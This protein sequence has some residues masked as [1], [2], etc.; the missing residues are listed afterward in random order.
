ML[1]PRI[2]RMSLLLPAL[3][4]VVLAFSLSGQPGALRASLPPA[5][6]NGATVAGTIKS[7]Q[8]TDPVRTAGSTGD[9]DVAAK[10]KKQFGK[11]GSGFTV[12][13]DEFEAR[14]PAGERQLENV[15]ATRAGTS[16]NGGSIVVVAPR[17]GSGLAG[18]S[19]TATLLELGHALGGETLQRTVVLASISGS[20]GAAGAARLAARLPGP[21]DAV[22]VLGDLTST[23]RHATIVV[24]WSTNGAIAPVRLRNT[25]TAALQQQAGIHAGMP[26]LLNQLAHLAFPLTIS[27]QGP[28]GARGVPAVQ[29]SFSGE[30]GPAAGGATN[31]GAAAMTAVGRG[32]LSAVSALGAGPAVAAPSAYVV[33]DKEIVP[34]WAVSLF[35][36]ALIAPV[37][38][39]AIDGFARARRRRYR[40]GRA[41]GAVLVAACPFLV[42]GLVV[43]IGRSLGAITPLAGATGPGV[44]AADGSA[45]AVLAIAAAAAVGVG[46]LAR[47]ALRAAAHVPEARPARGRDAR[48]GVGAVHAPKSVVAPEDGTAAAMLLVLCVAALLLWAANPFA[49]ALLVPALHLWLWAIDSDL[50]LP[51]PARI[52]M[53]AL[54][55]VPTAGLVV[56]YAH[57]LGFS[58]PQLVWEAALLLA[59]HSVSWAAAVEFS[60]VLGCLFTA[61]ALVVSAARRPEPVAPPVTVRGPVTYAGP[62]SLGGTKSALRR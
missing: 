27:Q 51:L 45:I 33:F 18:L 22:I 20:Q 23:A 21:V 8:K 37:A 10:V 9:R 56:F 40:V 29:L 46:V 54:G 38:L 1:D 6:F 16:S 47:M 11:T 13:T 15:V 49:A 48:A 55:A 57:S 36:L 53:L 31:A 43:L 19:G 26:D 60:A 24:P 42:A 7:L 61:V 35:V 30:R 3:A 62:G 25:L 14:T 32:V 59:G 41:L 39:T 50:A 5:A 58:P 17:D 12:S 2:Y 34:S 44:I 28:F 52:V 4:L